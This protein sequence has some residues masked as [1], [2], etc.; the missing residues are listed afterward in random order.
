MQNKVKIGVL[1]YGTVGSGLI[2]IIDNNKEKRNIEI[3][4]I[5]VNNLEKHKEKKYSNIITNNIDDIFEKDIDI[6]VEVMGGLEPTLSYIKKALNNKIHVVT[7]N[8][9]LL[10]E[11]GDELAKLAS[12][13]KVSIKFEASVAGG[14]PVLKPIIESLEG[15]NIDSIN[16]I[17]N[18]TTNFILSKMYDEDLSY[19]MALKQAQ[20]LGFA[21]ANPESDVLGYDAA[22]KLSILST[23]AYDNRVYWKDVY[24]EGITDIDEKDIEYAKKLNCKIKLIG[25][26]KYENDK[27]SAF[28][29]P[30]LVEKDNILARIDNEFNAVI[31]NGDSV[32]EVSFVGK[33]AGSLA[34][35]SAV[36]SDV[37][38]IIDNR[39][40]SIDSFTKDRIQV[41]KIV[42][43]KC[44]ALLRFK[45]CNKDEI[46]NIVGNC[47]VNYDILN[48]DDE[49]AIMVYADSEYE[50]NNSLCL[51]KDK[52][53]CEKMNKMLKIS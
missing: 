41:N 12:E 53:Y 29:R 28:V 47:L 52:G 35:G 20:E 15:N 18:G 14:I 8:K 23:L 39:V 19:D 22:R 2:D 21:E 26:S 24:L 48:D 1:G 16:A 13:N 44:G 31:V 25:Q 17:L 42:R 7:A 32:G 33:G 46:L 37:I 10:A 36:Y 9:D 45:K 34:T 49:L 30:V 6:L 3:V 27:V 5:L 43:E 51:I 38:D 40:S 50:I 11:C 4:G